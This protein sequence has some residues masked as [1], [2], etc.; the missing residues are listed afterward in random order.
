M[1]EI[2]GPFTPSPKFPERSN[3]TTPR[4]PPVL[5]V[6]QRHQ[7]PPS[8]FLKTDAK[9]PINDNNR[10]L[11]YFFPIA[12]VLSYL[13]F[14]AK[15]MSV[16]NKEVNWILIWDLGIFLFSSM[17][18]TLVNWLL[19][20]LPNVFPQKYLFLVIDVPIIVVDMLLFYTFNAYK[21]S[22]QFCQMFAYG[23][24]TL[25]VS[26]TLSCNKDRLMVLMLLFE[27]YSLDYFFWQLSDA[28]LYIEKGL[29]MLAVFIIGIILQPI[30]YPDAKLAV[31]FLLVLVPQK[32]RPA[33]IAN[34]T[35]DICSD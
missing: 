32:Y 22:Y 13:L 10:I 8:P 5:P 29:W 23:N 21:N 35:T 3:Q 14:L 27:S 20:K 7:S 26:A 17:I 33:A 18:L 24:I 1:A 6:F 28:D 31:K 9:A 30:S 12:Y 15:L 16:V 4:G 19:I 34:D 11:V 25:M 2:T